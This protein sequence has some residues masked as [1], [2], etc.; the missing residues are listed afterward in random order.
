MVI[1]KNKVKSV[2]DHVNGINP[3][4][5]RKGKTLHLADGTKFFEPIFNTMKETIETL[6]ENEY[7]IRATKEL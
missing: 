1:N 3:V 6:I 7:D 2:Y 5:H 4:W